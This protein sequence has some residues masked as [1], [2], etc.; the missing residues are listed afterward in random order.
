MSARVR[1]LWQPCASLKTFCASLSSLAPLPAKACH[2]AP[3]ARALL[4]RQCLFNH[5]LRLQGGVA[6]GGGRPDAAAGRGLCVLC[7]ALL[8]QAPEAQ[9]RRPVLGRLSR[10]GRRRVH[11]AGALLWLR[12][13][14]AAITL[15]SCRVWCCRGR[16]PR[17]A[18]RL[19][20]P[21]ASSSCWVTM[22]GPP[23]LRWHLERACSLL[24]RACL[25][26]TSW[27]DLYSRMGSGSSH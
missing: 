18:V 19:H 6:I 10:V 21:C 7:V 8:R 25:H 9:P 13:E 15:L 11:A 24:S 1:R 14:H 2:T 12:G 27:L 23:V 22:S 3:T 16:R 5:G 17:F 26:L 4:A 20:N